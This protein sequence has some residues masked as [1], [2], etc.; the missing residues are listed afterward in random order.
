M[1]FSDYFN[2]DKEQS[3]LDFVDIP[4]DTDIPL[5]IDPYILSKLQDEFSME[6]S[7]TVSSFFQEVVEKIREGDDISAK[8][9][10]SKLSEPND[11]H[12]GL[13]K[14]KSMGKGVSG[15]QSVDLF[16]SLKNSRAVRTGFVKDLEDCE[17]V[18]PGI[19]SDKISDVV[20]NTIK[21]LLIAYTNQ[22]CDLHGIQMQKVSSG[23][24]WNAID[25]EWD[26]QFV[27]L[28]IYEQEGKIDRVILVPKSI[29]RYDM[30]FNHTK[31]YN[32][33]VLTFLQ[34]QHI[35]EK[36]GLVEILMNGNPRV[37]KKSLKARPEYKLTKDFLY[38]F[39]NENPQV[40]DEY[41]D[42]MDKKRVRIITDESIENRQKDPKKINILKSIEE[43]KTIPT[44][45]TS[46]DKYHNAIKGI[47]T[48]IFHPTLTNPRKEDPV[49]GGRKRIDITYINSASEGFFYEVTN[50]IEVYKVVFECKN[51]SKD[52]A[53][54]ELDQLAGRFN[55]R[56]GRLGFV[57]CRKIDD[58]KKV[59]ERCK[60]AVH[61]DRGCMLV[62][63]DVDII[64][65][66]EYK[67]EDNMME[68][69]KLLS[70]KYQ[71]LIR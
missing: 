62:L 41:R 38:R 52:I 2:L 15:K 65:L 29:V 59:L 26:E 33:F 35:R 54:A 43:L 53:N 42:V 4:L 3:A 56:R 69:N 28:P 44:G 18:I 37:T 9:M 58:K 8:K 30:E 45:R 19:G 71:E 68:I 46:A 17:L 27:T 63:E 40:L 16:H 23:L 66:L 12:L 10:L 14:N 47:L 22:Q 6:A 60:D 57:V 32:G 5:F 51:Y 67:H 11:T 61:D 1:R 24:F 34:R 21:F 20:T 50:S 25:R 49:H 39:S 7:Q 36:S 31:Y 13:S 70:D 48:Q 64:K 55:K